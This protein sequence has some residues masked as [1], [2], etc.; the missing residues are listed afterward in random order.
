MFSGSN[1]LTLAEA[2]D[3]VIAANAVYRKRRALSKRERALRVAMSKAFR[4]EGRAVLD[5][6]AMMRDGFPGKVKGATERA[7]RFQGMTRPTMS[8]DDLVGAYDRALAN[9]PDLFTAPI[10]E[11]AA[12]ALEAGMTS[13]ATDLALDISTSV[14]LKNPRAVEYMRN[15]GAEQVTKIRQTTRDQLRTILT[16]A[17][18]EGWSYDETADAIRKRFRHFSI[19]RAK[20]I[21][22]YELGDAYEAGN[23]IIVDDLVYGGLVMEKS[24]LSAGDAKVR[25][26]HREND[27]AGW[28]PIDE[29]FPSGHDR[30]PTDPRCRC[31]A[32]YRRKPDA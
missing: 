18:D 8:A 19:E 28:I 27:A 21:A 16:Q 14:D 26:E 4:Q 6:L 2:V 13:A 22:V 10:D 29:D 7:Y 5:E 9:R 32:L 23:R 31:A 3:R 12:A 20:N 17:I 1:V 11:A 24:W 15:H 30:P 25:P